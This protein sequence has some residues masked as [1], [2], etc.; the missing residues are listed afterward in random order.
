MTRA[1]SHVP[2]AK[3]LHQDDV[4][5]LAPV[6]GRAS[7]WAVW[8]TA[9]APQ[10]RAVEGGWRRAQRLAWPSRRLPAECEP[11]SP[12]CVTAPE[13]QEAPAGA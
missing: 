8:V 10:G 1:N 3:C 13:A 9:V 2:L 5:G 4:L 7:F 12:H 6:W 11:A